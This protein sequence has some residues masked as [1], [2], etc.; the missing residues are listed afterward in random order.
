MHHKTYFILGFGVLLTVLDA[1]T[2]VSPVADETVASIPVVSVSSPVTHTF[3]NSITFNGVT[4]YQ[5]KAV[6]RAGIAG[7]VHHR[8]WKTG[9]MVKAGGIY[10]TITSKEQQALKHLDESGVLDKFKAP[11]PVVAGTGGI[12]TAVNYQNGDYVTEGD[13]LATLTQQSSLV[14]LV[15]VPVEYLD[16]VKAGTLCTVLLPDGRKLNTYLQA[17]LPSADAT[18]QTQ[19]FIVPVAS[20]NLPEGANLKVSIPLSK[21]DQGMA[22]P[23]NAVQTDETQEHFWVFKLG[24][25]NRAYKIAVTAGKISSDSL[26]EIQTDKI[27]MNDLIIVDGAYGLADSSTIKIQKQ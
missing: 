8:G 12:I 20:T 3:N 15:N 6:I 19:S 14:V 17:G 11:I 22:V 2:S 26:Q 23:V 18:V 10:C 21:P 1:C 16:Q 13:I 7:Y 9:D 25:G 4:Q 5:Q 27:G 24:K